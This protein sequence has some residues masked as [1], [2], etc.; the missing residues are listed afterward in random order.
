MMLA[1]VVNDDVQERTFGVTVEAVTAIDCWIESVAA[2]WGLSERVAFGARLC[3]AELAANVLEHGVPRSRED[4][5][6]IKLDR[7]RD[8][9][10]VEFADSRERFNPTVAPAPVDDA[11]NGGGRGLLL[12]HANARDLTYVTDDRYN[13]T[14]FTVKTT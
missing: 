13:R 8:G 3:V 4:Q 11:V 6:V 7:L 14:R 1:S 12:L 2:Q 10:E 9:I 5:I